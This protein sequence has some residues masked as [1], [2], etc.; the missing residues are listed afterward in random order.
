MLFLGGLLSLGHGVLIWSVSF[1]NFP[2]VDHLTKSWFSVI[3]SVSFLDFHPLN[4]HDFI[5]L[6]QISCN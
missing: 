6:S 2:S 3:Y 1:L 5:S 4:F